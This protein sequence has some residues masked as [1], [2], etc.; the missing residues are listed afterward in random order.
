MFNLLTLRCSERK[1]LA[2]DARLS[3]VGG[4]APGWLSTQ[5]IVECVCRKEPKL[6]SSRVR[7]EAEADKCLVRFYSHQQKQGRAVS[8]L[9][10]TLKQDQIV[11]S[12]C[13]NDSTESSCH[14][15][16]ILKRHFVEGHAP[17]ASESR[18]KCLGLQQDG[19]GRQT[20]ATAICGR[21]FALT[22]GQLWI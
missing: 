3:T 2:P 10:Q 1:S 17:T 20:R 18:D 9:L 7:S 15:N 13:Q 21:L 16:L 5:A 14:R 8:A 22:R 19:E 4:S 11:S 12:P 6:C